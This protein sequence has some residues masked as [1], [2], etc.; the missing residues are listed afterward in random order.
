[1]G[2]PAPGEDDGRSAVLTSD[3]PQGLGGRRP[4]LSRRLAGP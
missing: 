4:V 1:M 3:V 2:P